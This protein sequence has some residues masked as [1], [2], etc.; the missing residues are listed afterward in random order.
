MSSRTLAM[1]E[2]LWGEI[3]AALQQENEC[4]GMLI[5]QLI[6]DDAGTTFI[7]DSVQWAPSDSYEMRTT[8]ELRLRSQGWFPTA[9]AAARSK[10]AVAF[11]HTHPRGFARFSTMDD[12]VDEALAPSVLA[13]TQQAL[14]VSV[15]VAGTPENPGIAVRARDAR[16]HVD[17]FDKVR[18]VGDRLRILLLKRGSVTPTHDR[19]VRLLGLDGQLVLQA[20]RVGVVGAGGTG[21]AVCEQLLRL[22]VGEITVLDDD[23]VTPT[24]VS[25]GYGSQH[26]SVGRLKVEVVAE[27]GRRI[28]SSTVVHPVPDNVGRL[29]AAQKL[30]HCDVVFGCTDGHASRLVLNRLAYYHLAPLLDM[31]VLVRAPH[32]EVQEIAARLTWVGPQAACLL[33]RQRIDPATA[34][35]ERLDPL[36]RRALAAQGYAPDL[37]EPEPSVVTYTSLI[38]SMATTE[39]LH[40]L[41]GLGS[42]D[43]TETLLRL[44]ERQ[45]RLNRRPA[46]PDCFCSNPDRWA[47]GL[48]AP[49]LDVTWPS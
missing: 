11:L 49:Y 44:D 18:L 16:A 17:D 40:R 25:R 45:M 34:A 43:A 33:C 41:F 29:D 48:R 42:T 8:S 46:R 3:T 7:A 23:H 19:Q 31:G 36:E 6:A 15:V 12:D 24:T 4:A 47:G 21:S 2:A 35:V 20:L 28:G 13:L 39:L 30:R 5:G 38:A 32:G 10:R 14:Y 27:L 1:T 26:D 22:G 37:D 9:R